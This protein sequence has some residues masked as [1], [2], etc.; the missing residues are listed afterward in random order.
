MTQIRFPTPKSHRRLT[1]PSRCD[2]KYASRAGICLI[3][4][5]RR[6]RRRSLATLA[7]GSSPTRVFLAPGA[8]RRMIMRKS[9]RRNARFLGSVAAALGLAY[10]L[11]SSDAGA[12]GGLFCSS[13]TPVNQ[14]AERI[15]FA[16][17]ESA[18][19]VTAVIEILYQ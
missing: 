16:H 19:R 6:A 4:S 13:A 10:S 12:C 5:G 1:S 18:G 7:P 9:V 14:A 2:D 3:L 8:S 15:V 11:A 17:D